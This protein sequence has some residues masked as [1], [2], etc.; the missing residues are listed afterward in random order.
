VVCVSSHSSAR[1]AVSHVLISG[2]AVYTLCD[3]TEALMKPSI[4]LFAI[5]LSSALLMAQAP[6]V[7]A[8]PNTLFTGAD[9]KFDAPPDTAL[10]QFNISAHADNAKAAYAHD[11]KQYAQVTATVRADGND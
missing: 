8:A 7:N 10:V 9:G 1:P 5:L 4:L 3:E 6:T 2:G 11:C